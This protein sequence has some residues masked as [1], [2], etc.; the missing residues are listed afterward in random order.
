MNNIIFGYIFSIL[1]LVFILGI[2]EL[3][4][5]FNK[6]DN[7]KFI[8]RKIIHILMCFDWF[9]MYH[10]FGESYHWIILCGSLSILLL[11]FYIAQNAAIVFH[12]YFLYVLYLIFVL[13]DC[14]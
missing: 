5:K 11:I 2:G 8:A 4:I 10:F 9:I 14:M 7:F 6:S 13:I 1:W 3:L 12:F